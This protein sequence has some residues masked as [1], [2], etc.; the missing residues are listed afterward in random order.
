[1][2]NDIEEKVI[3]ILKDVSQETYISSWT[4][5]QIIGL[6]SLDVVEVIMALEK[7]FGISI[8]DNE[9]ANVNNVHDI[10]E[11]IEKRLGQPCTTEV[12][13]SSESSES[14]S[15][16]L[17][18]WNHDIGFSS[19]WNIFCNN[20]DS[21]TNNRRNVELVSEEISKRMEY[22]EYMNPNDTS[23]YAFMGGVLCYMYYENSTSE[24]GQVWARQNGKKFIR[25]AL[26]HRPQDEE[27][28]VLSYIFDL[29]ELTQVER[30]VQK[31]FD[32]TQRINK[33]CPAIESIS[34]TLLKNDFLRD[35]YNTAYYQALYKLS[36]EHDVD[37]NIPLKIEV[38]TALKNSQFELAQLMALFMLADANFDSGNYQEAER[39]AVLGKDRIDNVTVYDRENTSHFLWGL[40]WNIYAQCQEKCGE[41]DFAFTLFERGSQLGIP[42]CMQELARMYENGIS[43]D[44]NLAKAE[45]LYK[46]AQNIKDG[47][48]D[49]L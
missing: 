49:D 25:M 42:E 46:R 26:K 9:I 5:L 32:A 23:L 10:C 13:D 2:R 35:W 34:D 31:F 17:D 38:A 28:K 36:W 22:E 8:D 20:I 16:N 3:Q 40:C 45:E 37:Y 27:F 12:T 18:L 24:S 41:V 11:L 15:Q 29:I 39:Y 1:M 19:L 6:D 33:Q 21:Y 4:S 30:N 14:S 48:A 47:N 44:K 43:E 7:E